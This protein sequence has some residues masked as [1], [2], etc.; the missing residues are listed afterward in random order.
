[1]S[2]IFMVYVPENPPCPPLIKGG[3]MHRFF[4]KIIN[5][6]Y[7]R[8]ACVIELHIAAAILPPLLK[9]GGERSEPGDYRV[10]DG[11]AIRGI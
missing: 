8:G 4:W 2:R 7:Q 11:K 9:G 1:M 3:M 6:L 10:L 5:P